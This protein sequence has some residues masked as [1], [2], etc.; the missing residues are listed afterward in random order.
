LPVASD[1]EI[2]KSCS[3]GCMKELGR[4]CIGDEHISTA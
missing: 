2:D 3:G 4:S 1:Q